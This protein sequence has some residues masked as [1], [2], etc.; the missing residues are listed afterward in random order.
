MTRTEYLSQL[1]HYLRKL[2]DEDYTEAIDYFTEY[3][4]EA[5]PENENRV[6]E[7]LGNPKKA[8]HDL[9]SRLLDEKFV[10]EDKSPK[11]RAT[12]IWIAIL[13]IFASPIAVPLLIAFVVVIFAFI[14]AGASL[15]LALM[16]LGGTFL[17]NGIFMVWDSLTYWTIS[18]Q[19]AI[20]GV[21]LGILSF[22]LSLLAILASIET[23]RVGGQ[24]LMSLTR[25]IIRKGRK[26]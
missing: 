14:I 6:I 22:G 11:K 26:S 16:I 9:M 18:A 17:F 7:E 19:S 3:F 12:I 21:G 2:P 25:W 20:F 5:G 24:G 23:I 13:A 15:L 4:D 8:A 1:D 10:E